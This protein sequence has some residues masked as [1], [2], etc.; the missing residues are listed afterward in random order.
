MYVGMT[1]RAPTMLYWCL[2]TLVE[3]SGPLSSPQLLPVSSPTPTPLAIK[4]GVA[5][6]A[7][8][9]LLVKVFFFQI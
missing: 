7:N 4:V 1:R 2:V 8:T 9:I 3:V 6:S 5:S